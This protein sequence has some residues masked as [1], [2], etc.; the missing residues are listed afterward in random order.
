MPPIKPKKLTQV[1]TELPG[2][3][4]YQCD[5]TQPQSVDSLFVQLKKDG[6]KLDVLINNAGV[7]ETWDLTRQQIASELIAQKISTNYTGPVLLIQQFLQQVDS[8]QASL[9]VNITT[10]AALMPVALLPLYSASKAAL[11]S[12]TRSLRLQLSGTNTNVVEIMPPAVETKM[13][14]QDVKN[15]TK[16]RQP[17][18]FAVAIVNAIEAGKAEFS[19]GMNAFLMRLF[20][21]FLPNT[22]LRLVHHFSK[23]QLTSY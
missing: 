15:T 23:Q 19:P 17:D 16:M 3:V 18:E 11:R 4:V 10:E 6:R 7:V 14:T 21:R 13:T 12:F 5:V 22:G 1:Q 9:I 8:R 2:V 20:S